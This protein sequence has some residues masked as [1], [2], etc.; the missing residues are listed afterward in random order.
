MNWALATF[1][2][3]F[4]SFPLLS[5][6]GKVPSVITSLIHALGHLSFVAASTPHLLSEHHGAI[7]LQPGKGCDRLKSDWDLSTGPPGGHKYE[8]EMPG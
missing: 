8:A 5:W 3:I 2:S 4:E 6:L 7:V 1:L